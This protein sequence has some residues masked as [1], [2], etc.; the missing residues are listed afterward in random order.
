MRSASWSCHADRGAIAR[1]GEPVRERPITQGIGGG[2]DA[3]IEIL[4]DLD[5]G[6][7]VGSRS[8][9]GALGMNRGTCASAQGRRTTRAL[10]MF[11]NPTQTAI[12]SVNRPSFRTWRI[13]MRNLAIASVLAAVLAECAT[14][15]AAARPPSAPGTHG[16]QDDLERGR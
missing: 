12:A 8:H 5:H 7:T 10:A 13:P 2:A 11:P 14:Q 1:T 15:A 16:R 9:A 4:E 6:G 3:P